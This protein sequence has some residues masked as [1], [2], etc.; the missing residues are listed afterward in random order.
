MGNAIARGTSIWLKLPYSGGVDRCDVAHSMSLQQRFTIVSV[1]LNLHPVAPRCWLDIGGIRTLLL[2][3]LILAMLR[4]STVAFAQDLQATVPHTTIVVFADR[5]MRPGQW[6]ALLS[7]LQTDW[8]DEGDGALPL[9]ETAK[10][11]RGDRVE[12]GMTVDSAV[13]VFLHGNCDLEPLMRRSAFAVPLG[14]VHEKRGRIEPF[15]HVDCS[16]IGQVLGPQARGVSRDRRASIMAGAIA[17]VILHEWIH[18]A[19]QCPSHA[20]EGIEKAQFGVADLMPGDRQHSS[21]LR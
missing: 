5:P 9:S 19:T 10:F 7:A 11:I 17:K 13:V 18:I 14:W 1:N 3:L 21:M 6:T 16:R 2:A 20:Q 4:W 15:A 8:V 12:P